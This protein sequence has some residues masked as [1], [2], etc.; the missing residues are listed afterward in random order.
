MEKIDFV[1]PYVDAT[2]VEWQKE[3]LKYKG[4][5]TDTSNNL[6]RFR[7]WDNLHYLFRGLAKNLPWLNNVYL[8]V[9]SETQ[10]PS[11][12]NRKTVHVVTHKEFIPE[13]HLPTF[14]SQ[15]IEMYLWNI[16]GIADKFIYANDDVFCLREM[17]PSDFFKGDKTQFRFKFNKNHNGFFDFG[18]RNACKLANPKFFNEHSLQTVVTNHTWNP[19]IVSQ[20]KEFYNKHK[21]AI[22]N[23]CTKFRAEKNMNQYLWLNNAAALGK[24]IDKEVRHRYFATSRGIAPILTVVKAKRYQTVCINDTGEELVQDTVDKINGALKSAFPTACKYEKYDANHKKPVKLYGVTITYNEES[25]IPYVMPY[26]E[27]LGYDKLVVYDNESTDNTVKLLKK[28]PFVEVRTFSTDGKLNDDTNRNIKSDFWKEFKSQFDKYSVWIT[29]TDFDEVLYCNGNIKDILKQCD[30]EKKNTYNKNILQILC[31]KFPPKDK[32]AHEYTDKAIIDNVNWKKMLLFNANTLRTLR[33]SVGAHRCTQ[34]RDIP[35]SYLNGKPIFA[36]HLK[37]ID[38]DYNQK[39]YK[40]YAGRLSDLNIK[41]KWGKEYNI[42]KIEKN[43]QKE[44][45]KMQKSAISIQQ[46]MNNSI[47]SVV[48]KTDNVSGVKMPRPMRTKRLR[49]KRPLP[50]RISPPRI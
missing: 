22:D 35:T 14:N 20:M 28:Y 24:Q 5:K 50:R 16:P 40:H 32:L 45:N 39:K 3:Y 19:F 48:Q 36:F 27:R 43:W 2:D 49:T 8:L 38:Y 17:S 1:I 33:Y 7:S 31:D 15:T 9:A 10:V 21:S 25:M 29:A 4:R 23:S 18:S 41:K 47:E 26:Y 12:V 13:K 37:Y 11:W 42:Y 46:F 34:T 6:Q 30:V 44:W